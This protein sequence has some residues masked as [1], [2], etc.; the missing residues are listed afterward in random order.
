MG[1]MTYMSP[2]RLQGQ[3]YSY[4]SD[5]WAIGLVLAEGAL[6]RFPYSPQAQAQYQIG[7]MVRQLGPGRACCGSLRLPRCSLP[8]EI[9][10]CM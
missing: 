10:G 1:T 3:P 2:E 7:S 8:S 6:G 9:D 5:I 4:P